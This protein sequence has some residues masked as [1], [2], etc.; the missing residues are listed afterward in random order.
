MYL[1]KMTLTEFR[2]LDFDVSR[3]ITERKGASLKKK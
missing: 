2:D 1:S 3:E